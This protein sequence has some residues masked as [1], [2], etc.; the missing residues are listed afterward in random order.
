[1][2][3]LGSPNG[4][5]GMVFHHTSIRSIVSH[6]TSICRLFHRITHAYFNIYFWDRIE[7]ISSHWSRWRGKNSLNPGTTRFS[8]C[9]QRFR[10][11]VTSMVGPN[12]SDPWSWTLYSLALIILP[13][14]QKQVLK[15][16]PSST[17][18]LY[19]VH[20]DSEN[21]TMWNNWRVRMK[22]EIMSAGELQ[23]AFSNVGYI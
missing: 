12:W 3:F 6:H 14:T 9:C 10:G 5:S 19:F 21:K 18:F 22:W 4:S 15:R 8:Y 2:L 16:S 7:V 1:V 17:S 13:S 11:G 23:G 20:C